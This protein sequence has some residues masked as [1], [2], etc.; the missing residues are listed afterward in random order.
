M[1]DFGYIQII[2]VC[3]QKCLFCSNPSS[4]DVMSLDMIKKIILRYKKDELAGVLLTGGEPTMH[5]DLI[6]IIKYCTENEFACKV[7]TNGQRLAY[8]QYLR[9]LFVAGLRQLHVSIYSH[10]KNIQNELTQNSGAID[11]LKKAFANLASYPE[12]T[13]NINITINSRNQDHLHEVVKWVVDNYPHKLHFVFNNL[14]SRS[15]VIKKNP[16]VVPQLIGLKKSLHK[17]LQ[18]LNEKQI[19]FRVERVP[20]CYMLEF[21]HASTETRK[22]VKAEKRSL[23][24]LDKKG[25]RIQTSFKKEKSDLCRQCSLDKICAGV[26]DYG[27]YYKLSDLNPVTLTKTQI[28]GIINKIKKEL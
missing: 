4:G 2:R 11:N 21:A 22:M 6:D 15:L 5:P 18:F 3:N 10:K 25:K 14:D 13:L 19:T 26:D 28:E 7:I 1:A 9:A 12:L 16:Q 23:F 17:A 27:G 20:L 8:P 24:F